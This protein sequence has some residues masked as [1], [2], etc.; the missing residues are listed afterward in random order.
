MV[1]KNI[2]H[3]IVMYRQMKIITKNHQFKA[4]VTIMKSLA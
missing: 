2:L 3:K 1:K 4:T